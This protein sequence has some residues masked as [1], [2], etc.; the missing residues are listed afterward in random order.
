MKIRRLTAA[1]IGCLALTVVAPAN[2]SAFTLA[3]LLPPGIADLIATG[4]ANPFAP[5]APLAPPAPPTPPAPP[6]SAPAPP[7]SAPAPQRS[8]P[9]GGYKNCTEAW[10][11]GVAPLYRNDP[12]YAPHLDRDS[13]GK[14]C[15]V[16]PR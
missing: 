8:A 4:S 10:N 15:E 11:A 6:Q 2:A 7:Q 16:D 1:A 5:P 3:D 14:A 13:D 9:S 12:G